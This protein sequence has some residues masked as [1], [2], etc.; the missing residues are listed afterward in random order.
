MVSETLVKQ[1]KQI[2]SF[3]ISWVRIRYAT[4]T[5]TSSFWNI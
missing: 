2:I 4:D 1:P 3:G 5:S